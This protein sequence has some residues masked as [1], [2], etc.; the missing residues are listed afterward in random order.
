M[1]ENGSCHSSW[2]KVK[3]GVPQGSIVGPL[4]FQ[5]YINDL[6]KNVLNVIFFLADETNITGINCS[7]EDF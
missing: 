7:V 3:R 4:L 1:L 2:P 5:Y 6:P